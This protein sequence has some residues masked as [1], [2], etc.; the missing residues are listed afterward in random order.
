MSAYAALFAGSLLAATLLPFSSEAMLAALLAARPGE[1]WPL[2][3]VATLGNTLGSV[4]NWWI[5]RFA[6]TY[7]GR[8]WFPVAPARLERASRWFGRWGLWSLPFAWVP[9]VGDPLTVAAGLLRVDLP[10][11]VLLV[12]AGKALRYAAVAVGLD[13]LMG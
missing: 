13:A 2:L 11:F 3:A 12:G 5:G 8:R 4:I 7:R 6:S 1:V 9:V 10:R